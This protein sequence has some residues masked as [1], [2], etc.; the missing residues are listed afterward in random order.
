VA[1]T[2]ATAC[3]WKAAGPNLVSWQ[4]KGNVLFGNAVSQASPKILQLPVAAYSGAE[5]LRST[6]QGEDEANMANHRS[7][8]KDRAPQLIT[9]LSQ[10][11]A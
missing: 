3:D 6:E 7:G 8:R 2:I 9:P 4:S 1:P 5:G 11:T 10:P